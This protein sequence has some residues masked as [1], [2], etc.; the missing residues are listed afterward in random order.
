VLTFT[1][2]MLPQNLVSAIEIE[3]KYFRLVGLS[4]LSMLLFLS[5]AGNIAL[6]IKKKRGNV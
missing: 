6:K 3:T 2:S 1:V 4:V 5:A